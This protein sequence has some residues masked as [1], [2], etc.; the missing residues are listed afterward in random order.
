MA[1]AVHGAVH[2]VLINLENISDDPYVQDT[3]A[4]AEGLAQAADDQCAKVLEILK[5]RC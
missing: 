3:K 4:K 1:T 5:D 2:N